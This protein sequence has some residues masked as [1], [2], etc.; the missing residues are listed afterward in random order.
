MVGFLGYNHDRQFALQALAV[1]AARSDVHAVFAGYVLL[2]VQSLLEFYVDSRLVLMT[3]YGVV[4]LMT[5][6]QADEEHIVRQYKG[7]VNKC[8]IS[9]VVTLF[10]FNIF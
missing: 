8:V 5:G 1:S 9:L 7:I 6:Y 10:F 2:C 4:L 3:Y